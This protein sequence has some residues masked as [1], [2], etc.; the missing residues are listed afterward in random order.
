MEGMNARQR[1]ARGTQ[2]WVEGLTLH[3]FC[4]TVVTAGFQIYGDTTPVCGF[5]PPD[6]NKQ[7]EDGILLNNIHESRGYSAGVVGFS[8]NT[9]PRHQY[10]PVGPRRTERP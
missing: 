3:D 4:P 7:G 8:S 6:C 9:R 1:R 2:D 10:A 5:E